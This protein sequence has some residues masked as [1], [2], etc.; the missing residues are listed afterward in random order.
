MRSLKKGEMRYDQ[1]RERVASPCDGQQP[2]EGWKT[3][4]LHLFWTGREMCGERCV[5]VRRCWPTLLLITISSLLISFR[6]PSHLLLSSSRFNWSSLP[7]S[8][9]SLIALNTN[10]YFIQPSISFSLSYSFSCYFFLYSYEWTDQKECVHPSYRAS[11]GMRE[12][13]KWV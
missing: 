5:R 7:H 13:E 3:D 2:V 6:S 10:I 9:Y 4:Q 12:E 8:L 1:K 11:N